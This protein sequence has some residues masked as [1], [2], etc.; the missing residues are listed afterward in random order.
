MRIRLLLALCLAALFA[1]AGCSGSE[2]KPAA[3]PEPTT[4]PPTE[5]PPPTDVLEP[6]IA[7]TATTDPA[8][9]VVMQYASYVNAGDYAAASELFAGDAMIYFVG[10]PPVG[11]EIYWGNEQYHT[12]LNDCC[13]EQNFEMEVVIEWVEDGMVYAEGKT[14]MDFT[15]ALEVAPNSFH[16]V[17]VVKD[18]KIALYT[19]TMTEEALENFRPALAAVMPE[20]FAIPPESDEAPVSEI[21]VTIANGTCVY[22]G[23]MNLQA[24]PLTVNA[25]VQDEAWDKYAV[26][27]FTVDE[28]KD[29]I[30]LMASTYRPNP[31]PWSGI[32]YLR[33]MEPGESQ[34]FT[35]ETVEAGQLYLICW[36]GP[37]DTPIGNAGPFYVQP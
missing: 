12:F 34:T 11:M 33:E 2:S 8:A 15:R 29:L 1:L 30:D 14:W 4:V 9:A 32:V 7:S 36:A 18:G 3:N 26:S 25:E 24:G 37:P 28:G 20:A 27:F 35:I 19:S 22:H 17:F 23:P 5:T 10:M 13:A 16:E 21:E 6:T 31:P